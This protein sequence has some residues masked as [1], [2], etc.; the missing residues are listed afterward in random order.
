MK[1]KSTYKLIKF[2]ILCLV[3]IWRDYPADFIMVLG[4]Q[5]TGKLKLARRLVTDL[6]LTAEVV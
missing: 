3:E 2:I 1:T 4:N 5:M 6:V